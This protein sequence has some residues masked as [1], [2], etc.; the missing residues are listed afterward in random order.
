MLEGSWIPLLETKKNDKSIW[1]Y[2]H[3]SVKL[4]TLIKGSMILPFFSL[5]NDKSVI[6]RLGQKEVVGVPCVS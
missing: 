1:L 4:N 3:L 6:E 2:E 5:L